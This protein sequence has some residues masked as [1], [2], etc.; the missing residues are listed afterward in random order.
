[1]K[2]EL[3]TQYK[4]DFYEMTKWVWLKFRG[5][6]NEE[7][8]LFNMGME[9]V[10]REI[11]MMNVLKSVRQFDALLSIFGFDEPKKLLLERNKINQVHM[12]PST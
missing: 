2:K 8:Q 3:A 9:K 5:L 1:L 7:N 12:K 6:E 10:K 4:I 11:N